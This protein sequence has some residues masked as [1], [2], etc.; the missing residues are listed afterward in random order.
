MKLTKETVVIDNGTSELRAGYEGNL[1]LKLSNR[2]YKSKD[3][4]S[5]SPFQASSEKNMFDNDIITNFENFEV[6]LDYVFRKIELT[7]PENLIL[8]EKFNNPDFSRKNI[9][10]NVFELYNFKK[11]QLGNDAIYSLNHNKVT[12]P[13]LLISLSNSMTSFINVNE[14]ISN[15]LNLN[16]GAKQCK[17]YIQEMLSTKFSIKKVTEDIRNE[18]LSNLRTCIDYDTECVEIVQ[19]LKENNFTDDYKPTFLISIAEYNEIEKNN[20]KKGSFKGNLPSKKIKKAVVETQESSGFETE[21]SQDDDDLEKEY[22]DNIQDEED[23]ESDEDDE[24]YDESEEAELEENFEE[25]SEEK[26]SQEIQNLTTQESIMNNDGKLSKKETIAYFSSLYRFKQRI[27]KDINRLSQNII[28][29]QEIYEIKTDLPAFIKKTKFQIDSIKETLKQR[30]N[31]L[32]ELKNKRSYYS[33]LKNKDLENIK[34]EKEMEQYDKIIWAENHDNFIGI[35]KELDDLCV[36]VRK[37]E[38]DYECFEKTS[39]EMV[40]NLIME[41]RKIPEVLFEPSILNVNGIGITEVLAQTMSNLVF[42][43]GGF[44][45]I[46]GLKERIKDEGCSYSKDGNFDV[47]LASDPI[48]DSFNGATFLDIL[49]TFNS[50]EYYECGSD[51]LVKNIEF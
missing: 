12:S 39:Y 26:D 42:L 4:I 40:S 43:T 2:Y 29:M 25:I 47:I 48:Y 16:F 38:P 20:S 37:Y 44:S 13:C 30:D 28:K 14:R 23:S 11:L 33:L 22:N 50:Q 9:L 45:Q 27:L 10:E 35:R 7:E 36:K 17:K 15:V 24:F 18:L 51:Y 6:I 5:F 49:P 46:K 1:L 32:R 31:I 21:E 19:S 3:K 8:T 34:D 41:R